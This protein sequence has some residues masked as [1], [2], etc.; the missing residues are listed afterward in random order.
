MRVVSE[1]SRSFS[2]S[3]SASTRRCDGVSAAA[4]LWREGGILPQPHLSP[5]LD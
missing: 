5:W 1:L 3:S 4:G 2:A